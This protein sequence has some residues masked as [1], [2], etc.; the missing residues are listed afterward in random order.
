LEHCLE[1]FTFYTL[2][3]HLSYADLA[4]EVGQKVNAGET[5][6]HF[7]IPEE[8]G[9][10]PPHLHF[11]VIEDLEGQSGDYPGVCAPSMVEHYKA[12]CPD[13]TL[14]LPWLF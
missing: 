8:N 9:Y 4:I 14:L 3:G 5:F 2:Y 11:Q 13:P 1:G 10:W 6:A 7:G 12:N